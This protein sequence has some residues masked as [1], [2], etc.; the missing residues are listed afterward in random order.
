MKREPLSPADAAAL[1]TYRTLQRALALLVTGPLAHEMSDDQAEPR[2]VVFPGDQFS[3][4]PHLGPTGMPDER[5]PRGVIAALCYTMD[6]LQA[7]HQA[8][9]GRTR[10]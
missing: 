5:G 1:K 2:A 7:K 8:L 4:Y 9:K 3:A 6:W 10:S